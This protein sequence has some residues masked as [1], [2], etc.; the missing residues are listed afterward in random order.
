MINVPTAIATFCSASKVKTLFSYKVVHVTGNA[1]LIELPI[2]EKHVPNIYLSA[3]MISDT[4]T[5]SWTRNRSLCLRS[6]S[7]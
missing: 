4:R 2:E 5:G 3:S 1:K 6:S 7:F